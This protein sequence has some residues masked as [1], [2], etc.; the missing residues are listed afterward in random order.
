MHCLPC[1]N[2]VNFVKINYIAK[3]TY[4][5]Q[6][7]LKFSI[8]K[9]FK[10]LQ[11]FWLILPNQFNKIRKS[12][13]FLNFEHSHFLNICLHHHNQ[14]F[15]SSPFFV[16]KMGP[17][18]WTLNWDPTVQSDLWPRQ[19]ITYMHR[20]HFK[21]PK[22]QKQK[23]ATVNAGIQRLTFVHAVSVGPSWPGYS[24]SSL[25]L[26]IH[27][28][29]KTFASSE[30]S[31]SAKFFFFHFMIKPIIDLYIISIVFSAISLN[32]ESFSLIV[33]LYCVKI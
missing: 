9:T 25:N 23:P 28:N 8:A 10:S 19:D 5:W 29:F 3:T 27:K 24:S 11:F 30:S 17:K 18:C 31:L 1:D 7:L 32:L 26:P 20:K 22:R 21:E 16:H 2:N 12:D 6:F 33:L 13:T 14:F 15:S 4:S